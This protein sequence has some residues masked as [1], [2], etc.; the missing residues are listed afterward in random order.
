MNLDEKGIMISVATM[1]AINCPASIQPIILF[2]WRK[3]NNLPK[4]PQKLN[5]SIA[6]IG[7]VIQYNAKMKALCS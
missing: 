6:V 2:D 7:P 4:M 3:L 5:N 1:A